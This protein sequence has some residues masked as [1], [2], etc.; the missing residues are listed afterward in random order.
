MVNHGRVKLIMVIFLGYI[1]EICGKRESIISFFF[2]RLQIF[3]QVSK[4]H[5]FSSTKPTL[6][7]RWELP[8]LIRSFYFFLY[9]MN[10]AV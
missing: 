7:K 10:N 5:F 4:R 6:S 3:H 9:E 8:C 2:L 1:Q